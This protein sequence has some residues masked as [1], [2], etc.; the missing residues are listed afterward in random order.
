ME[1]RAGVS[2]S[3]PAVHGRD[4]PEAE[5]D[6]HLQHVLVGLTGVE[7]AGVAVVGDPIAEI[8][9]LSNDVDLL[10][11]AH[12]RGAA[13]AA[14]SWVA[15]LRRFRIRRIA[16]C[17]SCHTARHGPWPAEGERIAAGS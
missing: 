12:A 11:L 6:I 17:S 7:S 5:A 1:M 14:R 16:R 15:R 13:C 4:R 8:S 10:S 9:A 2:Y 3:R